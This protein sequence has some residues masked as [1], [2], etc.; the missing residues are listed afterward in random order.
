MLRKVRIVC[1]ERVWR[2]DENRR[3]LYIGRCSHCDVAPKIDLW[4]IGGSALHAVY[5]I[6]GYRNILLE[7]RKYNIIIT[8]L[9]FTLLNGLD[10][11]VFI[12]SLHDVWLYT[13]IL[14]YIGG[15]NWY[16]G[17]YFKVVVR[18]MILSLQLCTYFYILYSR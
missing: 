3:Y 14:Y 18:I 9:S 15:H 1:T 10:F 13:E 11:F 6:N 16:I 7:D 8:A 5:Y 17:I 2:F 4:T 12:F